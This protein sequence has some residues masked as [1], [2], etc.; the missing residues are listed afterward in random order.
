MYEETIDSPQDL[1]NQEAGID[2]A[3]ADEENHN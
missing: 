2:N 1:I 3:L